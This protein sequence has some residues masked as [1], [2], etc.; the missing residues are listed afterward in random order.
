MERFAMKQLVQ[1]KM[2][3]DRKPLIL[4]GARQTGKTWLLKEFGRTAFTETVYI[5]FSMAF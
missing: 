1:W 3:K 4:R 2:R 5:N